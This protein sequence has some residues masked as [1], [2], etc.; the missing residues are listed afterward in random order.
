[1][2]KLLGLALLVAVAPAVAADIGYYKPGR[3]VRIAAPLPGVWT[4]PGTATVVED[5]RSDAQYALPMSAPWL[6]PHGGGPQVKEI[7]EGGWVLVELQRGAGGIVV[8]Q[9]GILDAL[10]AGSVLEKLV[11]LRYGVPESVDLVIS[12]DFAEAALPPNEQAALLAFARRGGAVLF[13]H[14]SR[15]IPAAS[16]ALWRDLFGAHGAPEVAAPGLPRELFVPRGFRTRIDIPDSP[17]EPTFVWQRCGRGV[18]LAFRLTDTAALADREQAGKLFRRAVNN[19]REARRPIELRPIEPDAFGLFGEP[20]WSDGPRR[21]FALSA[22]GYA[23]GAAGLLVSFGG[24]LVKRR[25]WWRL[26]GMACIAACGAALLWGA[27]VRSYGLALDTVA[28]LVVEPDADPVEVIVARVSRLGP[29]QTP[30]L[31]SA[32][33]MPPRLLLY[34]RHAAKMKEWV[35]YRFL[36]EGATVEPVLDV[37]QALC[38]ASVEP[39]LGSGAAR[40]LSGPEAQP[41]PNADR[42]IGFVRR[43]WAR[44]GSGWTFRW[45]QPAV[46]PRLFSAPSEASFTQVHHSPVLVASRSAAE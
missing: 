25:W 43:R 39:V 9:D 29:G 16:V 28:I 37:G 33:P 3:W 8:S 35:R 40:A 36:P 32:L 45:T 11:E 41:P 38:L 19:V 20:G 7:P 24:L 22:W 26:G 17:D 14:M 23:A 2:K 44:G 27:T 30:Q 18:V 12:Y 21:E 6:V 10:P 13:I 31:R 1:M 34:G 46:P 5:N 42:I 15:T 4:A